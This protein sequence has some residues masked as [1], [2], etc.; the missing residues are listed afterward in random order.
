M[1]ERYFVFIKRTLCLIFKMYIFSHVIEFVGCSHIGLYAKWGSPESDRN[2]K[3]LS[4]ELC[5]RA[6]AS[7]TLMMIKNTHMAFVRGG[8][9]FVAPIIYILRVQ[10]CVVN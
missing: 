1:A 3:N 4:S 2:D 7:G 5:F 9:V 10:A 8:N 6:L